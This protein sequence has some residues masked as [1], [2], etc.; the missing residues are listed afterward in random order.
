LPQADSVAD[1][2]RFATRKSQLIWSAIACACYLLATLL[3]LGG[4][5][6][7]GGSLVLS[8][9]RQ[10]L[11]NQFVGWR[12]F[13]FGELAHGRLPL[14]NPHLFS[15][16]P[17]LGGFQSALLYPLN[18]H[19][20]FLPLADAINIG[21]AMHVFLA[22]LFMYCWM[23][24][25]GLHPAACILGGLI[26]MFGG[27]YFLHIYAGHLPN[28]CTMIWVPLIFLAIDDLTMTR[29]LR[30]AW[31][32]AAAT[33]MQI[34]AGHPQYVFYSAV[35]IGI[36]ALLCLKNAPSKRTAL[37]GFVLIGI[38]GAALSAAQLLTGIQAAAES[39]R[40]V[41]GRQS[42]SSFS[43]VPANLLTLVAPGFFGDV[44][45]DKYWGSWFLWEECVF[46]GAAA[47][48]LA[49]YGAICGERTKRRFAV[50]M[51]VLSVLFALGAYTPLFEVIDRLPGFS[52][53]RG[54]SKFI[55]LAQI[56]LAVLAA[57]GFDRLLR[58]KEVSLKPTIILGCAAFIVLVAA[59]VIYSSANSNSA[60]W[61]GH[62]I[63][64]I[65]FKGWSH[66][67]EP[68]RGSSFVIDT[69]HHAAGELARA[70]VVLAL[71]AGFWAASRFRRR[72]VWGIAAL[73]VV[74]LLSFA[75]AYCT[76]FKMQDIAADAAVWLN[77][78]HRTGPNLRIYSGD[79]S[80]MLLDGGHDVWGMDPMVMR[81]YG[82]YLERSQDEDSTASPA[83]T[84]H[85]PAS[86]MFKLLRLQYIFT[87][88]MRV[89]P[90]PF[91][92]MKRAALIGRARVIDPAKQLDALADPSFD[93]EKT[94]ILDAPPDL[95]PAG[96]D[97]SGSIEIDDLS[98][99]QVEIKGSVPAPA[100][101]LITDAYSSGWHAKPLPGSSQQSYQVIPA[102]YAF[103]AIPLS[104]GTHHLLMEY[105]PLAWVIGKWISIASLLAYAALGV[106]YFRGAGRN[107][108]E[109]RSPEKSSIKARR[110]KL[111]N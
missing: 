9:R 34:L 59:W 89:F 78:L 96:G 8:E 75:F 88:E 109:A 45:P 25:R 81:R 72:L 105:R 65:D 24:Y 63:G 53:F 52:S 39:I 74:E 6:F 101:L 42:A 79:Q 77:I 23:R 49:V 69:G 95:S 32:G 51:L 55:F 100:I 38:G 17:F 82:Q 104:A 92:V 7:S 11:A 94:V 1:T 87:A 64:A 97:V 56:F 28:L 93:P 67:H 36:Y 90:V 57:V 30:G 47:L 103:R 20:L 4:A 5:L 83:F 71:V 80:A 3:V 37:L 66:P 16:T 27:A 21:I 62:L 2:D 29:R 111:G 108:A 14:W 44:N 68:V 106:V 70:G 85:K 15:G 18:W 40:Q 26:F 46:V 31:L 54:L 13:G 76:T 41:L 61:W 91:A 84:L 99:D 48:S 60:G 86:P 19:Y 12:F 58:I 50:T 22:G 33:A 10:D 98:T 35:M 73:A 107:F 110:K 102:D 43:F